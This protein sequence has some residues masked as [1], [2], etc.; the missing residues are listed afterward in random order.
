MVGLGNIKPSAILKGFDYLVVLDNQAQ[1]ENLEPHFN[2]WLKLDLR[3]VVV[4]APGNET[5]FVS[6][7]FYPK[8]MV[9]EDPVTG[10]AHCQ[11]TPY[12]ASQLNRNRLLAKQ[13]SKR[14]G[15]IQCELLD[16]RVLLTG[17]AVDY[18]QGTIRL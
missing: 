1:L 16:D 11:L 4:T 9:D 6:R 14:T 8:L 3:G 7:C 15:T 17:N 12:W 2:E 18:L 5:D 10:S 13:L